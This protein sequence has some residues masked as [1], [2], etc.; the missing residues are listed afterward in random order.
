MN[1][2]TCLVNVKLFNN[3][4]YLTSV[5]ITNSN[6][7]FSLVNFNCPGV[8]IILKFCLHLC[9]TWYDT[10]HIATCKYSEHGTVYESL[11]SCKLLVCY[12][13]M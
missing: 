4:H 9:N 6:L 10:Q 1:G 11:L 13:Y 12:L 7:K 2:T 3:F 5:V 8:I